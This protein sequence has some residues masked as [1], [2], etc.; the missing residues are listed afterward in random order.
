MAQEAAQLLAI[1]ALAWIGSDEELVNDF[2]AATGASA[3]QIA[4]RAMDADFHLAILDFL[5]VDD[6]RIMAFCDAHGLP[7]T[8]PQTA[9]AALPGGEA[10]HWT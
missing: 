4:A 2:L 3:D 5:L 1:R 10:P 6:Q 9:R 7:Y 8:A